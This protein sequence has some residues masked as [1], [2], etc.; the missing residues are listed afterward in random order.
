MRS[1]LRAGEPFVYAYY[2]GIDKVAHE[3]GLGEHYDAE[4]AAADRLVGDLSRQL[5]PAA[6]LVV[7]ADHGQVEVGDNIVE[8]HR[9]VAGHVAFQS[10][11]GRFRWLHARP[12]RA[13]ALLEAARACHGRQAWVAP[14]DETDRRRLVRPGRHRRRPA[15]ARRRGARGRAAPSR[16]SIRPTPVRSSSSGATARSPRPRCACRSSQPS[17]TPTRTSF[18]KVPHAAPAAQEL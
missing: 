5:P 13:T 12:G 3:Y 7:T 14:G 10:G 11:E 9:D 4:L 15:P 8:L 2:D 16:S 18:A 1:L 17:L 6:A